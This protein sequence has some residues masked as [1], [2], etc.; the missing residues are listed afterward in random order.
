MIGED[1]ILHF[2]VSFVIGLVSP[3]L[4]VAAGIGKEVYDALGGGVAD[5]GDLLADGL[6]V[7]FAIVVSP[8]W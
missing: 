2:L 5:A 1:K 3:L 6:G 7:L 4:S 8:I